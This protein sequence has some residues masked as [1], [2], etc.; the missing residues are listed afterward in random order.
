MLLS[1]VVFTLPTKAPNTLQKVDKSQAA[2]PVESVVPLELFTAQGCSSCPPADRVL[3]RLN[4][5][6]Q[7]GE[8]LVMALSYYVDYWNRI[9]W[10]RPTLT[11]APSAARATAA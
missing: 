7:A 11:P 3:Q 4:A 1:V 5:A 6:A 10:A 8:G 2:S 9:G